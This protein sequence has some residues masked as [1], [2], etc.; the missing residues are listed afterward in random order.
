VG[1]GHQRPHTQDHHRFRQQI[2][3][4]ACQGDPLHRLARE[5]DDARTDGEH[6]APDVP[7]LLGRYL[8]LDT[9]F[10]ILQ[11]RLGRL[12]LI[13]E[14]QVGGLLDTQERACA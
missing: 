12:Q 2:Q 6:V 7:C 13:G 9:P 3:C 8:L 14:H 1:R 5:I 10:G 11:A 4:L